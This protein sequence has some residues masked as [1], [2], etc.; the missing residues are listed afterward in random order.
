MMDDGD[1]GVVVLWWCGFREGS[2]FEC[3]SIVINWRMEHLLLLF[4]DS[5]RTR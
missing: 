1:G 5:C 4:L 3:G 2:A